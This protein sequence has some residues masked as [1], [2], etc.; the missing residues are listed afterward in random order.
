MNVAEI[1][2]AAHL[3][4]D[5]AGQLTRSL[6]VLGF[7]ELAIVACAMW[8]HLTA[9][10]GDGEQAVGALVLLLLSLFV[11]VL[12]LSW[13]KPLY[14]AVV[15]AGRASFTSGG[16]W[17]WAWMVPIACYILPKY[18]VNDVWRAADEPGVERPLP[19]RVLAWWYVWAGSG[20]AMS[21]ASYADRANTTGPP[22]CGECWGSSRSSCTSAR[23]S[24]RRVPSRSSPTGS[25][26]S[27]T[28]P[29]TPAS[30]RRP[31]GSRSR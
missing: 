18:L 6:Y 16:I 9:R 31:R 13:F 3:A 17:F 12:W 21:V 29:T 26:C 30:S 2:A 25:C 14:G 10:L 5:R 24:S 28:A 7:V 19:G 22:P 4:D 27:R 8:A 15:A 20:V 11:G 1:R 23:R